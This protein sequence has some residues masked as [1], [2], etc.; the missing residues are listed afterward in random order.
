MMFMEN[1]VVV[2]AK[3]CSGGF[4]DDF[5]VGGVVAAF[6]SPREALSYLTVTSGT[7]GEGAAFY[8]SFSVVIV[9]VIVVDV[10]AVVYSCGAGVEIPLSLGTSFVTGFVIL[11]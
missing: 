3:M 5:V 1:I 9:V 6:S 11:P 7:F 2:R 4:I 10:V 8:S